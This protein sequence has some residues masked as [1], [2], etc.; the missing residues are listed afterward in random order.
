MPAFSSCT[1]EIA[2][3]QRKIERCENLLRSLG[4]ER[5]RRVLEEMMEEAQRRLQEIEKRS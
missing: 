5:T 2:D 3:L 1:D 4:D